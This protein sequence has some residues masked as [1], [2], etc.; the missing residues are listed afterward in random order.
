[1]SN[2]NNLTEYVSTDMV[3]EVLQ[4]PSVPT[5]ADASFTA[6]RQTLKASMLASLALAAAFVYLSYRKQTIKSEKDMEDKLDARSLGVVFHDPKYPN[7]TAFLRGKQSRMRGRDIW[8][9]RGMECGKPGRRG[10]R[11]RRAG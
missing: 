11:C 3:M 7:F 8:Q 10:R 2:I 5:G 9:G 4:E 6:L 1:M